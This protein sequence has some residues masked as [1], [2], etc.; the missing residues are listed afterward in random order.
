LKKIHF[1]DNHLVAFIFTK[2][3]ITAGATYTCSYDCVQSVLQEKNSHGSIPSLKN[4][5]KRQR[6][7]SKERE[8]KCYKQMNMPKHSDAQAADAQVP[9]LPSRTA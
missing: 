4:I 3:A 7:L 5:V 6:N 8:I 9:V 1:N 2:R